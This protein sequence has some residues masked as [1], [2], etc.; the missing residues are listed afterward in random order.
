MI[1]FWFEM[2]F[3]IVSNYFKFGFHFSPFCGN[4]SIET[5]RMF[6]VP[7]NKI[8]AVYDSSRIGLC[9][10]QT[11]MPKNGTM[12]PQPEG[13]VISHGKCRPKDQINLALVDKLAR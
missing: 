10:L 3:Q 13:T 4:R 9:S 12:P 11:H 8:G 6:L 1:S 7:S 2:L 5:Y